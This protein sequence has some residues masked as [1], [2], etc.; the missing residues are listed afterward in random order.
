MESILTDSNVVDLVS[1]LYWC[2]VCDCKHCF[3]RLNRQGNI[4]EEGI[5]R[6]MRKIV[7]AFI[8]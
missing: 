7:F 3:C 1:L 5:Q 4:I 8:K 2:V 6:A